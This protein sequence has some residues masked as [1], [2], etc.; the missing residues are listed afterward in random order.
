MAI[1]T[2]RTS[3]AAETPTL[4]AGDPAPDFTLTS[5]TG[6]DFRLSDKRGTNLVLAFYPFA[7]SGT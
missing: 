7:F 5:H 3:R 4:K 2:G 6:E 1:P